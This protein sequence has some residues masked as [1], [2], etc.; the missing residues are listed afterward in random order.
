M[1]KIYTDSLIN[2][3]TTM[4]LFLWK[5]LT[6]R[7]GNL[8]WELTVRIRFQVNIEYPSDDIRIIMKKEAFACTILQVFPESPHSSHV[9]DTHCQATK[10]TMD[11]R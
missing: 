8:M 10:Q 2:Y 9:V 11:Q 1:P 5:T 4:H 3:V 6:P 7:A